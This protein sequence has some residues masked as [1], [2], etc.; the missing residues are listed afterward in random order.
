MSDQQSPDMERISDTEFL[1]KSLI[2]IGLVVLILFLWQLSDVLLL[3]FGSIL[4]AIILHAFADVLVRYLNIPSRWSLVT[5]SLTILVL[6]IGLAV[7]FG[8]NI[9]TQL[10]NVAEQLPVAID[11]FGQKLGIGAISDDLSKMLSEVPSSGL[12]LR[13]AGIGGTIL[14]GLTDFVLVIIAGLYIAASPRIYFDG[15]VKLFPIRQHRRVESTL[16]ASGEALKLWLISQLIAMICVGILSTFAFWLIGLPSP[17]A[18]GLIASLLEFIPF[19]GPILGALPAVLIS[20]TLG[21]ETVIWTIIAAFIIQQLEGNVIFPLVERRMVSIP[22]A[23]AL[24][25]IVVGGILFGTIGLM[26]GFPLVVVAYVLVKKLY[27]RETL[28]EST[29]IPGETK[30]KDVRA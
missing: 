28:G 1:R 27:V 8:A 2:L 22:P 17:Y 9:R 16:V 15:F 7:F 11:A 14:S 18:L 12:A 3:A 6:F 21:G 26:L 25:G 5:A 19:L 10:N 24:F 30:P 20:F 23:L 13:I 4:V 29:P